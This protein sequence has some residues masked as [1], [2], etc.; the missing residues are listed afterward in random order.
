MSI[1]KEKKAVATVDYLIRQ[2]LNTKH[3]RVNFG[4]LERLQCFLCPK[5]PFHAKDVCLQ[6]YD[7]L[8]PTE[9][10]INEQKSSRKRKF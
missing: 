1:L 3:E 8:L 7:F 5:Y 2:S 10:L 4:S 6:T 9:Q